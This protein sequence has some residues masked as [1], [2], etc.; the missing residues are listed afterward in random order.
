MGLISRVSSRTYR[1]K[2]TK[3]TTP[4]IIIANMDGLGDAEIQPLIEVVQNHK[5][6]ALL[7]K[8]RERIR[9]RFECDAEYTQEENAKKETKLQFQNRI[10][11]INEEAATEAAKDASKISCIK[12]DAA[13]KISC[14]K[15]EAATEAAKD[16]SK[17]SC[18]KKEAATK[19]ARVASKIRAE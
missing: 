12:E 3:S 10:K 8:K 1:R 5:K 16:A 11:G 4:L 7:K 6:T 14:I 19:A 17:I 15:E 2:L 9:I 13:S 18:I